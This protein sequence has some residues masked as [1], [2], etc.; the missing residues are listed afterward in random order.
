M[1]LLNMLQLVL[2]MLS[3][4]VVLLTFYGDPNSA[5]NSDVDDFAYN[6]VEC[7]CLCGILGSAYSGS[8]EMACWI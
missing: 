5:A 2:I 4:M 6:L 3:L 8:V 1:P 7:G